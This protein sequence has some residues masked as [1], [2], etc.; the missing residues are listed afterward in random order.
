[1]RKEKIAELRDAFETSYSRNEREPWHRYSAAF[2]MA[3]YAIDDITYDLV[4]KRA[5]KAMY[6]EKKQFKEEHGI[7][8]SER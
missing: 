6:E 1:M 5:D 8:I 3:E 4:F 7:P 2:G